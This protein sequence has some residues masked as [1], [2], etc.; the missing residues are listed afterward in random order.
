MRR[1]DADAWRRPHRLEQ[2]VGERTQIRVEA[3]DRRGWQPQPRIGKGDDR[4]DSQ[5]AGRG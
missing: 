3:H 5:G 4:P 2:I 1:R